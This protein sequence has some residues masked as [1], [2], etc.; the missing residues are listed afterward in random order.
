MKNVDPI[1]LV[2]FFELGGPVMWPILAAS[3]VG[4][5]VFIERLIALRQG[6]VNPRDFVEKIRGM[7]SKGKTAQALL[8]C[9]EHGASVSRL[10]AAALRA[11][12][13]GKPRSEIKEAI[14]EVGAREIGALD[15][16]VEV[17]GTVASVSPLLGLFGTVVGMIQVFSGYAEAYAAGHATPD[18]FAQGIYTAL[19]TTAYGLLVAIPTFVAYKYLL[20]R[21]DGLVAAMEEDVMSLVDLIEEGRRAG[22]A[23]EAEPT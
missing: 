18:T 13:L 9:D 2:R 15:K 20:G 11:G 6:K 4:T 5:A 1:A 10:M 23:V 14:A 7:A 21:T 17:V 8:L 19:I 16:Y 3:L 22:V 12:R